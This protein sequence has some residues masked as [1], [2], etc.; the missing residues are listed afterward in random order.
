LLTNTPVFKPSQGCTTILIGKDATGDGS[1][2]LGHN[3]DM[4]TV[5]GRLK[6][7][8]GQTHEEKEVQINYVTI[9]QVPET[10]PYWA[11]GNSQPVADKHYDGGWVLCGMNQFGVSLGCNTMSTREERIPRG[12]GI[13][14]YSIRQLIL[15]RSKSAREAVDLIGR[16]IDT[17]GQS[18]SPVAYCIADQNEAW[19]VETTYRQWVAKRIPDDGFHVIANQYTIESEWDLASDGLIEY[20]I[21]QGWYDPVSGPFNLKY[22]YCDQENLDRP[23]NTSRE[24]QGNYMLKD[25]IG[26]ITVKDVLHVLSQPP[27]QTAGTQAFMVW[28]LRKHIPR[29]IGCVMWHGMCGANTSVAVPVFVG[30]TRVPEEFT[31]ASYR[32]DDE[33]AWWQFERLQKL[34]YPRWWEYTDAYFDVRKKLNIYQ[35]A[36]YKDCAIVEEKALRM[37]KQ[38]DTKK[39]KELLTNFT[40]EKLG[41]ALK[42]VKNTFSLSGVKQRP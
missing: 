22:I 5:S 18:D 37:W 42:M 3:E 12:K 15:E 32:E 23:N 13:M 35:E 20:A 34:V 36:I 16:L 11:S 33:S 27:I 9:P 19:L 31:A 39:V 28:H 41:E 30:S 25:K 40:Y 10:V 26:S 17:Y 4:G 29:E 38:G 21:E 8:P 14:R 24:F 1:V 6:Y 7:Q 2:M